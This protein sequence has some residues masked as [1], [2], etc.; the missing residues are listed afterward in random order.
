MSAARHLQQ[1]GPPVAQRIKYRMGP[2]ARHVRLHL[3]AG[4]SLFDALVQPLARIGIHHAS[5][6]LLGGRLAA[7]QYCV[8]V[9]DPAGQALLTHSAPICTGPVGLVTANATLATGVDGQPLV[10]CHAALQAA[11]GTLNG[12]HLLTPFCMIA[13]AG[14]TARIAAFEGFEL[15]AAFDPETR[16]PLVQPHG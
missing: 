3:P 15:R 16:L 10:H 2:K 11:D 7:A 1:P 5:I 14:L 6:T 13:E 9:P 12:G 4:A 8:S